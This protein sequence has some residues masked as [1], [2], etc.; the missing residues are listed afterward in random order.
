M[1]QT[2]NIVQSLY[3]CINSSL[4]ELLRI[5]LITNNWEI[6]DSNLNE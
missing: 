1:L 6:A 4:K 3:L 2:L 5:I